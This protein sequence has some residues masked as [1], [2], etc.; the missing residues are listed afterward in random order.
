VS[1]GNALIK[2]KV[3]IDS[4]FYVKGSSIFDKHIL[5]N[6]ITI[7]NGSNYDGRNTGVGYQILRAATTGYWNDAFGNNSMFNLT[8]GAFNS[9]FGGRS[10]YTN[11]SGNGNASFGYQSLFN[12]LA[13]SN[14]AFGYNAGFKNTTGT[15]NT[16]IGWSADADSVNLYNATAIGAGAIVNNSNTIQLGN[17]SL[18]L[19]N[20]SGSINSSKTIFANKLLAYDSL[21]VRGNTAISG[22]LFVKGANILTKFRDDSTTMLNNLKDSSNNLNAR[23]NLKV[24]IA[25]TADMLTN[26]IQR[27]TS[28]LVQK[29]DTA[30][31]LN[32]RFARDTVSLSKRIDVLANS[33]SSEKITFTKDFPVR[34]A[35]NKTF[36]K[37]MNTDTVRAKGKTLDE[38][39]TDIVTEI[40]HP[41]YNKPTISISAT[42]SPYVVE[43]GSSFPVTLSLAYTQNQG[44]ALISTTYKKNGVN[45]GDG[46]N[47]DSVKFITTNR[48]FTAISSF[49]KGEVR[50]NNLSLPDSTNIILAGSTNESTLTYSPALKKYWG[51]FT[52]TTGLNTI[53]TNSVNFEWATGWQKNLSSITTSGLQ[54]IYYAY[55][56]SVGPVSNGGDLSGSTGS[57]AISV[58]GFDSFNAFYK[59]TRTLTNAYGYSATYNIY[60]AK[61]AA[62]GTVSNIIIN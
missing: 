60:I 51:A 19:V 14:A 54:Y 33:T 7:G 46:V 52:D 28:Y 27:D 13:D 22:N 29:S 1:S 48:V 4:N 34:I 59:I 57:G 53:I 47:S 40:I 26:R 50:N 38:L 24:N 21:I 49:A 58:G 10:M 15:K 12:N 45:I 43:Y 31:M 17:T 37:Y 44:G 56:V 30:A 36:G 23:I 18:S 8:N 2:G 32:T 25:D 39:L 41:T 62:N 9:S 11:V 16:F 20:T 6:T 61:N 35:P 3:Q 55:P 42:P 5:V